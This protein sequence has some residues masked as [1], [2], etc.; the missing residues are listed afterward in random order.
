MTRDRGL[1]RS[2]STRGLEGDFGECL[3]PKQTQLKNMHSYNFKTKIVQH[4]SWLSVGWC[5]M[6]TTFAKPLKMVSHLITELGTKGL[7]S[8]EFSLPVP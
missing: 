6:N 1:T 8:V 4:K 2:A 3:G 7:T 5:V